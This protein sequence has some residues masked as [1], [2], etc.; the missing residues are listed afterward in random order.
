[1]SSTS[2]VGSNAEV[3]QSRPLL[4]ARL[5]SFLSIAPLGVWTVAHLW[6]NL[7]AFSGKDAWE[8]S[9]TRYSHPFSEVAAFVIVLVPLVLHTVWG[10]QRLGS[11]RPNNLRYGY[12]ANFKY[13]M[14][15][16]TAIGMVFFLGAHLWL[17]F[18]HPRLVEG[19]SEAFEDISWMMHNHLPTLLVY[20]VGTFAVCYHLANGVQTFC[21]TWGIAS[22]RKSMARLD[23]IALVAFVL[24]LAMSYGVIYAM[25]KAGAGFGPPPGMS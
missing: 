6:N 24:L 12:Y 25:W 19:H 15:R 13:F 7:S 17:A 3:S 4:W 18:L 1:M 5:G 8:A 16:F 9:V 22:G 2:S 23:R 20:L 21:W 11:S 10:I 14:Q